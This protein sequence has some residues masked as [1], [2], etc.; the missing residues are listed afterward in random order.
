MKNLYSS[1]TSIYHVLG[2][3][4][5][6]SLEMLL[7]SFLYRNVIDFNCAAVDLEALCHKAKH[8]PIRGIT[9]IAFLC[10][11]F[12]SQP[13]LY[14]TLK[15][16]RSETFQFKWLMVHILG[17]LIVLAP[18]LVHI[19][20]AQAIRFEVILVILMIGGFVGVIGLLLAEF[21]SAKLLAFLASLGVGFYALCT[22]AFFSFD[23]F[24][25]LT[26]FFWAWQP[27]T[28]FTFNAVITALNLLGYDPIHNFSQK[29]IAVKE[30][31]V[32]V[33]DSCSGIEG[34]GLVI[35]YLG[36][37]VWMMREHF[38][39]K[40]TIV[41]FVAGV[42]LSWC[43]NTF[44]ITVLILIGANGYPDLAVNGF[45]SHAGWLAFAILAGLLS[46]AAWKISWF[47]KISS[48]PVRSSEKPPFFKDE[49]VA[50]ILPFIAFMFAS[51]LLSTFTSVTGLHYWLIASFIAFVLFMVRGYIFSLAWE[52]DK[53]SL[54]VGALIA[55]LWLATAGEPDSESPLK[56]ALAG[57]SGAAFVLWVIVRM[58]G[59]T[60]LIPITEELFFRK[61]ML[62]VFPR[63]DRVLF[64]V[65]IILSTVCFAVLH[66]RWLVA[67]IAGLAFAFLYL[68]SNNIT[69]A[70]QSHMIANLFIGVAAILMNNWALI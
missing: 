50:E 54:I 2:L 38:I 67:A 25:L 56:A 41:L 43:L 70:I 24:A 36:A 62:S 49:K 63:D 1:E 3:V 27:V 22:F 65:S 55:V 17:V 35:T 7:V 42:F 61:Y 60:I 20:N 4:A 64:A 5:L 39:L 13:R 48:I 37:F 19:F 29:F 16:A 12:W 51:L 6:L 45:H 59:T 66:D 14:E 46:T 23:F 26:A 58:I 69:H 18:A 30:F 9:V 53:L 44:R 10:V 52:V 32:L 28:D 33:A 68:R 21:S 31:G 47:R 8:M 34:F 15:S 40:R 11:F 57:L